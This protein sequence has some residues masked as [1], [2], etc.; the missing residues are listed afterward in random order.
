MRELI[1][2]G[3]P[4]LG[5]KQR[6]F[7][8]LAQPDANCPDAENLANLPP[9]YYAR[10]SAGK[11][12]EWRKVYIRGEYGFVQDG[13]PVFPEF[14]ENLHVKLFELNPKIPITVGIDFGNTPAAVIGQRSFTGI[15]RARWEVCSEHMGAREFAVILRGFLNTTC[16]AFNIESITGDPAGEAE[17]QA[18]LEVPFKI[19]KANGIDV[20]PAN[21][22]DPVTRREAVA[23][24]LTQIIDG[25]AGWQVHP[26]GC[27]SL[28]A[29]MAGKY[30]Y[31]RVQI[32]GSEQYH[33]KPDK[34]MASHV[35]E[36]E[37]YRLLGMGEGTVVLRG[38]LAR[39]RSRPAYS[40]T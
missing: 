32:V 10:I 5:P 21:T 6:L 22:N 34:N 12:D 11:S 25:Q 28:R 29:G 24:K 8:F 2:N 35:C 17:G 39:G 15:Q 36:A 3:K 40:I 14:R 7:E 4:L 23:N 1:V 27:P 19:M 38:V 33:L 9:G 37:E 26:Q 31:K 13:R 30:R 16:Q 20:K 18:D